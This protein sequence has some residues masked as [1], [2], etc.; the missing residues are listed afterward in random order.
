MNFDIHFEQKLHLRVAAVVVGSG[1]VVTGSSVGGGLSKM[2]KMVKTP[3]LFTNLLNEHLN[4]LYL[5]N[6]IWP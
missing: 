1:V 2:K 3:H 6:Q 5:N 4:C